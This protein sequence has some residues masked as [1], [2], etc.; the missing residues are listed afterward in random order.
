MKKF[1][2][3]VLAIVSVFL[4]C[5]N[6]TAW[7]FDIV[8][9]KPSPAPGKNY[10]VVYTTLANMKSCNVAGW[11]ADGNGAAVGF[12]HADIYRT[13]YF[14]GMINI[15]GIAV[16]KSCQKKGYGK[17]L[18]TTAENW[19]KE[20]GIKIVR[21]KKAR[22]VPGIPCLYQISLKLKHLPGTGRCKKNIKIFR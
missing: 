7:G 10:E 11:A 8:H 5:G 21:L 9:H 13:L 6:L 15:L 20:K 4:I 16:S 12:V 2:L 18:M 22:S 1:L 19:S 17:E 3:N 14:E